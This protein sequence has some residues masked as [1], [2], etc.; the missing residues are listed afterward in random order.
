MSIL[1]GLTHKGG[2][3]GWETGDSGMERVPFQQIAFGLF[4]ASRVAII[5]EYLAHLVH[6]LEARIRANPWG[7]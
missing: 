5:A 3:W 2:R 4:G 7:I 1:V 6:Q